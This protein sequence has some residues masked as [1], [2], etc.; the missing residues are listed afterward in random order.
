MPIQLTETQIYE[1]AKRRV[2][3]KR[4]F[5]NHLAIYIAVN[6]MLVLIW[7]FAADG[8]FPWFLFPL[9]GWGIG[10]ICH[11]LGV[12]VFGGK[13]DRTAIEKEAEKIRREQG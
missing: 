13:M 10:I 8:G 6:I 4:G 1:E 2:E 7:A 9:G 11:F 3:E 12:F 5:Y